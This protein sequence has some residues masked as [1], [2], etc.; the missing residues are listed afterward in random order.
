MGG[1]EYVCAGRFT[2]A[3]ISVSYAILLA[4]SIGIGDQVP[5]SLSLYFD[6][7]AVRPAFSRAKEAQ[8]SAT[9]QEGRSA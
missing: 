8:E 1:A 5:Q 4:R 3:D 2:M 7:L 6:R 9:A